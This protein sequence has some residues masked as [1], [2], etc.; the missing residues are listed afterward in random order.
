MNFEDAFLPRWAEAILRSLL[1]PSDRESISGDLLEEYRAVQYPK[2][3]RLRADVWYLKHVS[4]V[5]L[6]FI[7]PLLPAAVLV[8]LLQVMHNNPWNHSPIPVPGLTIFHGALYLG[9]GCFASRRTGSI[10]TGILAG[11]VTCLFTGAITMTG[12]VA[13]SPE[14]YAAPFSDPFIFVILSVIALIVLAVGSVAGAIGGM[15]GR[16]LGPS[17]SRE[18]RTS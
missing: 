17:R 8:G 10:R 16:W 6:H 11:A 7:W 9:A 18:V 2:N 15:I 4:S 1:R 3:G 12:V 5:L 14:L 13:G